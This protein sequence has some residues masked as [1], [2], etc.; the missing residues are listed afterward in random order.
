MIHDEVAMKGIET[1]LRGHESWHGD[2]YNRG[3]RGRGR[4]GSGLCLVLCDVV[5]THA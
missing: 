3:G 4:G 1:H 2:N 5:N